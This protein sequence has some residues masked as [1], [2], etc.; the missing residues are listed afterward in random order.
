MEPGGFDLQELAVQLGKLFLAFALCFPMAWDRERSE[1]SLGVRTIPLVAVASCAFVLVAKTESAG[2]PQAMSRVVQGIIAGVGFLGGGAI[3]K[4]GVSVRGAATAATVWTT[5]ALGVAVGQGQLGIAVAL[6]LM[7]FATLRWLK[8]LK[9]AAAGKGGV[10]ILSPD[11]EGDEDDGGDDLA[12]DQ[13]DDLAD[14]QDDTE[15]DDDERGQRVGAT[16]RGKSDADRLAT[17]RAPRRS[18]GITTKAGR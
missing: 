12:D 15:D 17:P 14:D 18:G 5:A 6:G 11:D 10:V 2:D 9:R 16:G 8:P 13:D 4:Q 3:V 1:R 7:G